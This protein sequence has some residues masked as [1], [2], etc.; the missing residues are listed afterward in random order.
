MK[1]FEYMELDV[2]SSKDKLKELGEQGWEAVGG[3]GTLNRSFLFKRE[4]EN[5]PEQEQSRGRRCELDYG[6]SR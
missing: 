6:Y 2:V 4:I 5:E 1:Q 3:F